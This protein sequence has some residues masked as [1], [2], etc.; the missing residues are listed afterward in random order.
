[1]RTLYLAL[2]F[3]LA[4]LAVAV[5]AA[6]DMPAKSGNDLAETFGAREAVRQISLS[7]DGTKVAIIQ[8]TKGRGSALM[9]GDLVK[10]S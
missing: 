2:A 10:A 8:P 5:A 3:G 6:Q 1:M 4:P 9:I 7:P